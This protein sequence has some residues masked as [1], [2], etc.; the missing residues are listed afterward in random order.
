MKHCPVP[1][2]DVLPFSPHASAVAANW[3]ALEGPVAAVLPG[4]WVSQRWLGSLWCS[5]MSKTR[6]AAPSP[7]SRA[8]RA[9]SV[10]PLGMVARYLALGLGMAGQY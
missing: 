5:H 3:G 10:G 2:Q 7:G 4:V 8:C 6:L 9:T 1:G